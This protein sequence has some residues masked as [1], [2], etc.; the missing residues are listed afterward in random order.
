MQIV[1]ICINVQKQDN[2]NSIIWTP[3][4]PLSTPFICKDNIAALHKLQSRSFAPAS[5]HCVNPEKRQLIAIKVHS[6]LRCSA[7][8][9]SIGFIYNTGAESMWG[10]A[11]NAASLVF[12]LDQAEQLVKTTVYKIKSLVCYLQVS[13]IPLQ[14]TPLYALT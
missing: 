8:I 3:P 4:C 11:N 10:S 7:S 14:I 9:T 5:T 2:L 13:H 6:P 12:F 1:S